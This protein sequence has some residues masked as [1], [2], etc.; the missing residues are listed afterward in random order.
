LT[1]AGGPSDATVILPVFA[2]RGLAAFQIGESAAAALSMVPI[3]I[4]ITIFL[5]NKL[6]K[7]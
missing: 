3:A 5:L 1:T 2:Y 6:K 7:D 4:V